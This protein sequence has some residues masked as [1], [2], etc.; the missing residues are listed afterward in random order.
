[1]RESKGDRNRRG[2]RFLPEEKRTVLFLDSNETVR[3]VAGTVLEKGGYRVLLAAGAAEGIAI[4]ERE[5]DV[6]DVIVSDIDWPGMDG[7]EVRD[8]IRQRWPGIPF[9][10]LSAAQLDAIYLTAIAREGIHFVP[11]PFSA[12]QLLEAVETAVETAVGKEPLGSCSRSF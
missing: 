8:A 11:K 5:G 6:I 3:F 1:M 12:L 7:L 4:A 2:G 10:F 9:V